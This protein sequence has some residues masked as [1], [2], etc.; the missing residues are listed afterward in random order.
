MGLRL[1]F[2]LPLFAGKGRSSVAERTRFIDEQ[3][4][5]AIADGIAQ[6]VIVGAV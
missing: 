3:M 6:I 4:L 2:G 5:G 1:R